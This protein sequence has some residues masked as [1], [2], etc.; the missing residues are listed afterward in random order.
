[1]KKR[2]VLIKILRK[3]IRGEVQFI[4]NLF[5]LFLSACMQVS[6][7]SPSVIATPSVSLSSLQE[8]SKN[9][10]ESVLV[11][12]GNIIGYLTDESI[13]Y[14]YANNTC[15]NP[16]LA[17]SSIRNFVGKGVKVKLPNQTKTEVYFN[18]SFDATC[19]LLTT[20]DPSQAQ[21][22]TPS[23]DRF[24]PLSPSHLSYTPIIFGGASLETSAVSLFDDDQC[25]N[26]VGSGTAIE[27]STL[28]ILATYDGSVPN[29][30][31]R[32]FYAI[33]F[34]SDGRSSSC[35]G[36]WVY[37][38]TSV[39]PAPSFAKTIPTSPSNESDQPLV[40]G[41]IANDASQISIFSD[42]N[43]QH[44]VGSGIKENFDVNN[45][46]A[47]GIQVSINPQ[48]LNKVTTHLYAIAYTKPLIVSTTGNSQTT[49][50]PTSPCTF[51][52]SYTYKTTLPGA[53]SY[54][55]LIVDDLPTPIPSPD[56]IPS[57]Y[58][59]K[60]YHPRLLGTAG[61][62]T[63][64]VA[65]FADDSCLNQLGI[66]SR[67]DFESI[68][69]VLTANYS[70]QVIAET[71]IYAVGIDDAG[72]RSGCNTTRPSATFMA[73][74][75]YNE[76]RPFE[77]IIDNATP[78]SQS[79]MPLLKGFITEDVPGSIASLSVVTDFVCANTCAIL[80]D[81]SC[82]SCMNLSGQET[83]YNATPTD[84]T[85][86]GVQVNIN[87]G[88]LTSIYVVSHD[89]FGNCSYPS[90]AFY[91]STRP[92][93]TFSVN[94][95]NPSSPTNSATTAP[96]LTGGTTQAE[97]DSSIDTIAFYNE[98]TCTSI[99]IGEGA[100]NNLVITGGIP[101][102]INSQRATKIYAIATDIYFTDSN[103]RDMNFTYTHLSA[104]LNDAQVTAVSEPL[105]SS[106]GTFAICG[107]TPPPNQVSY[108]NVGDGNATVP[109]QK[110]EIYSDAAC[111]SLPISTGTQ[112]PSQFTDCNFAGGGGVQVSIAPNQPT[113]LFAKV[114]DAAGNSSCSDLHTQY[115]YSTR[116]PTNAVFTSI[117]PLTPSYSRNFV[118]LGSLPTQ[119]LASRDL[120][121]LSAV[122][123]YKKPVSC[124][125]TGNA[126]CTGTP[127]IAVTPNVFNGAGQTLVA[128]QNTLTSFYAQTIDQVGHLSTSCVKM[129]DFDH[130]DFGPNALVAT[131]NVDGS[132]QLSWLPDVHAN[133]APTYFVKKAIRSGGPYTT[134]GTG[135]F[136]SNFKDNQTVNQV[137][138]YYVVAAT[139][140]TG[141]SKD[142]LES[143]NLIN[144]ISLPTS[145]SGLS[146]TPGDS[147]IQLSWFG[148]VEAQTY[149]I[150][151]GSSPGGPY[152]HLTTQDSS[153]LNYKD[154]TVVN[155]LVYYYVVTSYNPKG[156]SVYSNES[157][158][159]PRAVP[160]APT[161][162]VATTVTYPPP[163]SGCGG[164]AV[165]L[166]WS[167]PQYYRNSSNPFSIYRGTAAGSKSFRDYSNNNSW[168]DCYPYQ[169]WS[170]S[171]S[172]H[173]NNSTNFYSVK[174]NWG[175]SG[176]S[177]ES[178]T[179]AI[180][181]NQNT[182]SGVLI[183]PGNLSNRIL[184][185]DSSNG[186][187]VKTYHIYR[188]TE[189]GDGLNL[190]NF[191]VSIGS[192]TATDFT[193]AAVNGTGLLNDI[194]YYY[195][196]RIEFTN[197][198]FGFPIVYSSATPT[199]GTP[200]INPT[201]S[202]A[203]LT[204]IP[205]PSA[206]QP[207]TLFW[208][209]P[210]SPMIFEKFLVY[211]AYTP[212]YNW[213]ATPITWIP[214]FSAPTANYVPPVQAGLNHYKVS[215]YRNGYPSNFESAVS[216]TVSFIGGFP[217][218][219]N[220]TAQ[221]AN[222]QISWNTVANA[223][224]YVIRRSLTPNLKDAV[225]IA[226]PTVSP[227]TDTSAVTNTGYFY[228][229]SPFFNTIGLSEQASA[230]KSAMRSD[231]TT[232]G[233]VYVSSKTSNTITVKWTGALATSGSYR[234]Y[235]INAPGGVCNAFNLTNSTTVNLSTFQANATSLT[236][237]NEYCLRVSA[238]KSGQPEN[239][240]NTI[241][242]YTFSINPNI[243]QVSG[244]TNFIKVQ[245]SGAST[246]LVTSYE[247]EKTSD[248]IN[249][250]TVQSG[251]SPSTG[252]FQIV[253]LA[254]A[255]GAIYFY[256]VLANLQ[257]GEKLYSA[258]SAGVSVNLSPQVPAGL[259][260]TRNQG[261][262]IDLEWGPV[263]GAT[264]YNVWQSLD[265]IS[266][267]PAIPSAAVGNA[268]T[269][270]GGITTGSTYYFRVSALNGD[271][272]SNLSNSVVVVVVNAIP[273]APTP[274]A[275]SS[276]TITLGWGEW[277]GADQYKVQRSIDGVNF[278]DLSTIVN[279]PTE[280]SFLDVPPDN[281]AIPA[282]FIY[283][284]IPI[285]G[286]VPASASVE[287]ARLSPGV[288]PLTPNNLVGEVSGLFVNLRWVPVPNVTRY[289]I[290][291]STTQGAG[292]ASM[293]FVSVPTTSYSE[294]PPGSATYFYVIRSINSENNIS[295][296][297]NE[298]SVSYGA[299]AYPAPALSSLTF[300][301]TTKAMEL[302]WSAP[303][304]GPVPS[305]YS[306]RRSISSGGPFAT[307][308]V[309]IAG[310][311]YA[312]STLFKS[313]QTYYY[314]VAAE[315]S[316]LPPFDLG[317]TENSN[318]LL[319]VAQIGINIQ[320]VVEFIDRGVSS[321]GTG[322]LIFE[323]SQT[324]FSPEYYDGSLAIYFEAQLTNVDSSPRSVSVIDSSNAVI[325]T[326]TVPAN[327]LTATRF[328][329]APLSFNINR[330]VYRLKLEMTSSD[331]LLK[332]YNGR[333]V[334]NQTQASKT[335]IYIPLLALHSQPSLSDLLGFNTQTQMA[336]YNML[337][338]TAIY[339]RNT[340]DFS[341]LIAHNSFELEALVATTGSARGLI[342]LFNI[343]QNHIVDITETIFENP[344]INMV[345]ALFD[346]DMNYFTVD[347]NQ[348]DI[349][350]NCFEA[351]DNS[352]TDSLQL[353]KAGLWVSLEDASKVMIYYRASYFGVPITNLTHI[354][355]ARNL[356]EPS[357]FSNPTVSW[358]MT[359][360]ENG[361]DTLTVNLNSDLFND[362]GTSSLTPV[363]GASFTEMNPSKH[364]Q[365]AAGSFTPT[366]SHR[367]ILSAD[368][369]TGNAELIHTNITI[370]SVR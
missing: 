212:T 292:Y 213:S 270:S 184:F 199:S 357:L 325:G 362:T 117:T 161:S 30:L 59:K 216:N 102:S 110:L 202:P 298:T 169:Y 124:N 340:A 145:P 297:S 265:D 194:T 69:I 90:P 250:S 21:L 321:S 22:A 116:P 168:W 65:I 249:F 136:G 277:V 129:I 220:V 254:V 189:P 228:F 195:L 186:S 319:A 246:S 255:D 60:T 10:Q 5:F 97:N 173:S 352:A 28:G 275:I 338:S 267:L 42:P 262:Q 56:P 79:V 302:S 9:N 120:A 337:D 206:N 366:Q 282:A 78:K 68:G 71:N 137:R 178:N 215:A 237:N 118:L 121:P 135:I 331:E 62:D 86:T 281:P 88:T 330:D 326:I 181:N 369:G 367:L 234:L 172:V 6:N 84:F 346:P 158:G 305:G 283:R 203:Q 31:T 81:T 159:Q 291:R 17:E 324:S 101:V 89:K 363:A 103:C 333:I 193:D 132:M 20:Y 204:L 48:R 253:D 268:V 138:Y 335:R 229:I 170:G 238:L 332:I 40:F 351:C 111:G 280:V 329:S 23:F 33:G 348:Y 266:F 207:P 322:D 127:Y 222:L 63:T 188:S 344:Q 285:K 353:Y 58:S 257:S 94:K 39:M 289:E 303:G 104:P 112:T 314:V 274:I 142:S 66:G 45:E 317:T 150:Y 256:R 154:L 341:T 76:V 27:F 163:S 296:F 260:I 2:N 320:S 8:Q 114:E 130:S 1:V 239:F 221:T 364:Y 299:A 13:I 360:N 198:Y 295:P 197:G 171:G 355:F 241:H 74:F 87:A 201:A 149:K 209:P 230:P 185:T 269:I 312:D 95:S 18:T 139:N 183:R 279:T 134:I 55:Y 248:G 77:S 92:V 179:V 328:R 370:K 165:L 356:M 258:L 61:I 166:Q 144:I 244:G 247:I 313:Q 128:D 7:D 15:A 25:R 115:I 11:L 334:I 272:Q 190:E 4:L 44:V 293:G 51:L 41:T 156:E 36:P 210:V 43:C 70:T 19:F 143:N 191:N 284:Y 235:W 252:P 336:G 80:C 32:K 108:Q 72:N 167:A 3:Q 119:P 225:P 16:S 219:V 208:I 316:N 342:G 47:E 125:N 177:L 290:L 273:P 359:A 358:N 50:Y 345:N 153:I 182:I 339:K 14:L 287:S 67:S 34:S 315:H 109:L 263:D 200:R 361:G 37:E 286:G 224:N 141:T 157:S 146:A 354:D 93:R 214:S 192:V 160:N 306:I 205:N 278:V 57:F 187:E 242:A 304:S 233:G 123:I 24:F 105:I 26:L 301:T 251:L 82:D 310:T 271:T 113:D 152:T 318:E 218:S 180:V 343:S 174:A 126:C 231:S 223:N 217:S 226:S 83:I 288:I 240:S 175:V 140:N 46:H 155:N 276:G 85:D 49:V 164:P 176:E 259:S 64:Q 54:R 99:K 264:H 73:N 323:R 236:A 327:T 106:N 52:T 107:T 98:P 131:P 232:P 122:N 307:V 245:W 300:N 368:P 308:A 148:S 350:L 196:V 294:V 347:G 75:F 29:S 365:E 96:L 35:A 12:R 100:R 162:L 311:S 309:G 261:N 349:R 151:R 133:P 211:Q 227:Y 91:Y 147:E 243:S 38:Y 53:P